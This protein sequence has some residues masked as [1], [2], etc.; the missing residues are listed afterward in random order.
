[1]IL[2]TINLVARPNMVLP[3][4]TWTFTRSGD[5]F[6]INPTGRL[7]KYTANQVRQDYDV[8]EAYGTYQGVVIEAATTNLVNA[9]R[10]SVYSWTQSVP[11]SAV[12]SLA[13]EGIVD[14]DETTTAGSNTCTVVT[15]P[16]TGEL[17]LTTGAGQF[18]SASTFGAG[19]Y[20]MSAY[21]RVIGSGSVTIKLG[22]GVL[23]G[24]N[25]TVQYTATGQWYR[26]YSGFNLST[27]PTSAKIVISGAAGTKVRVDMVQVEFGNLTAV[28]VGTS[29]TRN[30]ET[31][32]TLN[33]LGQRVNEKEGTLFLMYKH[34]DNDLNVSNSIYPLMSMGETGGAYGLWVYAVTSSA[35]SPA[36][37]IMVRSKPSPFTTY[38]VFAKTRTAGTTAWT[39]L[40]VTYGVSAVPSLA[41]NGA[42]SSTST[43][44]SMVGQVISTATTTAPIIRV[45][46]EILGSSTMTASDGGNN[47]SITIPATKTYCLDG[48][49][50]HFA[51]FPRALDSADL[52]AITS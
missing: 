44:I 12:Q 35:A 1:M 15:I 19:K 24:Q 13:G 7:A 28:A 4:D 10:R 11:T 48:N 34:G 20:T 26:V 52:T 5:A 50:L 2:P 17:T 39:K 38:D 3:S 41:I 16:S 46:H 49:I 40:A 23:T 47:Y 27:P 29:G 37:A 31:L 8:G 33:T 51:Y 9:T 43:G 6:S 45:G 25:K 30:N 21:V 32:S 18:A 42:V 36:N 22:I 14:P